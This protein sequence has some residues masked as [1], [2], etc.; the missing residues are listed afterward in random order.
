VQQEFGFSD[1]IVNVDGGAV[2]MG[3]PLGASGGILLATA[4]D[5][6]DRVDGHYALLAIPAALGLGTAI[7]IERLSA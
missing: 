4:M 3:H 6:L 1:E 7:I 5:A 2:A